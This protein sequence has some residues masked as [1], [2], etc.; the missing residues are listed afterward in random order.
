MH[1]LL[2][3][4]AIFFGYREVSHSGF[5]LVGNK[6]R[7]WGRINTKLYVHGGGEG[8]IQQ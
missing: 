7:W 4:Q 3:V 5:T 6:G 8:R 1:V 2:N